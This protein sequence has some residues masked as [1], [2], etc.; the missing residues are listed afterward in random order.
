MDYPRK[1]YLIRHDN[2]GRIYI[3][4]SSNPERRYANHMYRLK[5]GSHPVEDMQKDFDKYGSNFTFTIIDDIQDESQASK[6]FQWMKQF[7]SFI[8]G[9]GYNYKDNAMKNICIVYETHSIVDEIYSLL[10]KT[11]DVGLLELIL[12]LL[13]KSH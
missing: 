7:K 2:T 10:L 13:Q 8:R 3:G 11:K 1:I 4:S 12:N 5:E 9:V 6:E